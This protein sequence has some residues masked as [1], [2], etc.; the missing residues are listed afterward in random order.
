MVGEIPV[1]RGNTIF[2]LERNNINVIMAIFN[3]G[4]KEGN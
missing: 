3:Y 1:I 4:S 2:K